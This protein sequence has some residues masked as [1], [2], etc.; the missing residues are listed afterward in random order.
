[1]PPQARLTDLHV[2]PVCT[3]GAPLPIVFP[4]AFTVLVGAL[5]AARVTDMCA[6]VLTPPLVGP[7]PHPILKGSFTVL[8]QKLPAARMGDLCLL[9]GT[10][11]LGMPTVLTGG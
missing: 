7:M 9:G 6:G 10:I 8:I 2:G 11:T 5:P 4:G 1:M 3:L